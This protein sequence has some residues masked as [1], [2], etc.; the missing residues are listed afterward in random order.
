M[1][2]APG[3]TEDMCKALL[4]SSYHEFV[5]ISLRAEGL[6]VRV[7]VQKQRPRKSIDPP[8]CADRP[9]PTPISGQPQE[10]SLTIHR[11]IP[12]RQGQADT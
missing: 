10:R 7:P 9:Y 1:S 12:W 3:P 4:E 5:S 6:H 11:S 8:P 2:T